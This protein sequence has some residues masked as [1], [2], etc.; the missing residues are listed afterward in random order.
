MTYKI[1]PR[2]VRG[3]DYYTRTVFEVIYPPLGAQS[4][5][6]GGGRYDGLIEELGGPSTPGVGFALGLERLLLT[7]DKMGVALPPAPRLDVY[8]ASLGDSARAEALRQLY[9]LR[10]AGRSAEVDYSGRSFRKQMDY[11]NKQRARFVA[12]LGD[13]ELAR[14]EAPLKNMDTGEQRGVPLAQLAEAI[15]PVE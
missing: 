11:A 7:L 2:I 4:T 6:W 15:V 10:A 9:A 12:I 3:L 8:L 14:G 5:V 1:D 13:D